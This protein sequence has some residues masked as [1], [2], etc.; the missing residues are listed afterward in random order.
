MNRIGQEITALDCNSCGHHSRKNPA[1]RVLLKNDLCP[2]D[3]LVMTSAVY[4][5]KSQHPDI[6]VGVDTTAKAIWDNNP[7]VTDLFPSNFENSHKVDV[8]DMQYPLIN[9]SDSAPVHFLQGYVDWLQSALKIPIKL[10]VNRPLLYLSK[11]EKNWIPQVQEVTGTPTKY[12]VVNAGVKQDFTTKGWGSENYQ[13]VVDLLQGQIKFVQIGERH[14]NHV[15]LKG[16]I[17]LIGKTDTRQF[18]RLCY[19]ASGGLGPS[20]FMQHIFAAF[21]KPYVCML[22]GREPLSWVTYP[23]QHTFSSHGMLPC[24]SEKACWKSKVVSTPEN[25]TCELPILCGSDLVPKC[26]ADVSPQ[27]V[28][29]SIVKYYRSGLLTY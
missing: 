25:S 12:W 3:V 9:S 20:T 14:H 1:K 28:V 23:T 24:C 7:Y 17:N 5:L 8:L 11:A 4:C 27:Q 22:G 18:I 16:V 29:D 19:H 26:L 13:K 10:T 21:K 2:G 15:P 6:E